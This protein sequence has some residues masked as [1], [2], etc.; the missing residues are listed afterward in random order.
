MSSRAI[1]IVYRSTRSAGSNLQDFEVAVLITW[2]GVNTG[3]VK[4]ISSS[5]TVSQLLP[6]HAENQL[7]TKIQTD[8]LHLVSS[9]ATSIS[10][11][12]PRD[13]DRLR[14]GE[15]IK[16]GLLAVLDV[17]GMSRGPVDRPD[18]RDLLEGEQVVFPPVPLYSVWSDT[19]SRSS[20]PDRI[21]PVYD[22]GTVVPQYMHRSIIDALPLAG[23]SSADGYIGISSTPRLFTSGKDN[24]ALELCKSLWRLRLFH[25]Q[26]WTGE[27]SQDEQG[28][29][30]HGFEERM[31]GKMH[32]KIT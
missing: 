32:G 17:R 16:P 28:L 18:P 9:R 6:F 19:S 20:L 5:A 15:D 8:F 4:R 26:G 11:V 22:L 31:E 1:T 21:V 23:C 12:S 7:Q 27:D 30:V 29:A 3:S 25:G 10:P 2:M 13:I 24:P 14:E